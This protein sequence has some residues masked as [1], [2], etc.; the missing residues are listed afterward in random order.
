M[1][2][3]HGT[4]KNV[5]VAVIADGDQLAEA[6]KAG[7]DLFGLDDLIQEISKGNMDFDVLIA[8][9]SKMAQVGKLGRQLGPKG[10]MP[11]PKYGTVTPKVE[12]AINKFKSGTV[13]FRAEKAGLVHC[14]VGK[15]D[16]DKTAIIENIKAFKDELRRLKPSTSKGVYFKKLW[17]SLTMSPSVEVDL[18]SIG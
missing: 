16:F 17:L 3:P 14:L 15:S 8:T 13:K 12:V 4:G 10:L 9:P 18:S 1:T 7:A 6:E 2:F 11:N 5:R